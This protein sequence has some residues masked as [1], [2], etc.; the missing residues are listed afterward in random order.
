MSTV[1]TVLLTALA[2][3]VWGTTYAVT[4]QWLPEDRPL[5]AAMLRALPAGLVLLAIGHRLPHGSWWWRAAVLGTLNIGAFFALLF[6]AAYRLPG[7]VAATLGAVQ[8]LVVAG[9]A[10]ALLAE[11]VRLRTALAGLAGVTGIALL[12]LRADARLDGAGLAAGLA[13]T[14][15]VALGMVLTRRWGR[16]VPLLTFTGWQLAAGGLALVPVVLAVEGLP[17]GLTAQN[18]GGFAY[19][20]VVGTAAAYALWFRGLERLPVAAVS[21]LGLLSP[22]VA[23]VVGWVAL[24]EA[25]TAGQL[26]GMVIALGGLAVGATTPGARTRPAPYP[27]PAPDADPRRDPVA[28]PTASS[29]VRAVG[30]A[31]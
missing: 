2:P 7:G 25:L 15:C 28:V 21:F 29:V 31:R 4:T 30:A 6:V 17:A 14:V 20:G 24:G 22:V 23:T 26:A 9:L 8:P 18:V 5:L 13:G 11:R 16:P 1:R 3:A 10:A 19:L 12:V 27:E